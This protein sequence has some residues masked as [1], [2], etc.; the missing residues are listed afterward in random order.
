MTAIT[1]IEWH[2]LRIEGKFDL[3]DMSGPVLVTTKSGE[4]KTDYFHRFDESAEGEKPHLKSAFVEHT[5]MDEIVAW[6]FPPAPYIGEE[7]TPS[8]DE[9]DCIT[10]VMRSLFVCVSDLQTKNPAVAM[11]LILAQQR[12]RMVFGS[13]SEDKIERAR[14]ADD[15]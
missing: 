7:R 8:L 3:P 15:L 4:V 14:K 9:Y 1:P 10:E 11:R 6:A 12:I 13:W 2:P 5:P